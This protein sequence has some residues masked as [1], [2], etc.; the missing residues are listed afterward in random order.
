M[1]IHI[2]SSEDCEIQMYILVTMCG[3]IV[4]MEYLV[5]VYNASVYLL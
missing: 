2:Y 1:Y 3:S 5:L 4:Y